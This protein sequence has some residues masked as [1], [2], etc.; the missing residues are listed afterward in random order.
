MTVSRTLV[1][2]L[3]ALLAVAACSNPFDIRD[4]QSYQAGMRDVAEDAAIVE[5]LGWPVQQVGPIDLTRY[6]SDGGVTEKAV[7]STRVQG[8][9]ATGRVS[10]QVFCELNVCRSEHHFGV[11]DTTPP[12]ALQ[13]LRRHQT[14]VEVTSLTADASG[15]TATVDIPRGVW[16]TLYPPGSKNAYTLYDAADG[17]PYGLVSATGC[18]LGGDCHGPAS[19]VLTFEPVPDTVETVHLMEGESGFD[20]TEFGVHFPGLRLPPTPAHLR[21]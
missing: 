15:V 5:A 11:I 7:F 18:P 1:V 4:R 21:P 2:S 3:S 12:P 6:A 13:E 10:V 16:F 8:P 9:M 17:T 20:S 19:F 14:G